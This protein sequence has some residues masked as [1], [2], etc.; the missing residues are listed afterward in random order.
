MPDDYASRLSR[1]ELDDLV[2]YLVS[3][4]RGK[5]KPKVNEE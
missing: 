1:K 3:I 5:S 4:A 2:S